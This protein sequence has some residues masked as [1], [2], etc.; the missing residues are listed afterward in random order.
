MKNILMRI[1]TENIV[2]KIICCS[3]SEKDIKRNI[4]EKIISYRM[5]NM[6]WSEISD[7]ISPFEDKIIISKN[8]LFIFEEI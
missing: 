6:D 4:R 3:V 5:K 7:K 2:D 1:L 8:K